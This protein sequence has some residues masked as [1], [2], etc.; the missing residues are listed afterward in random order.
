MQPSKRDRQQEAYIELDGA[1]C[2]YLLSLI[3]EMDSET[4]Y[5]AR[6]RQYTVPKLKLIQVNPSSKRLAHQ[7]VEYL[8]DLI[9]DDDLEECEQQRLMT[10]EKLVKIDELQSHAADQRRSIE[11]QRALRRARRQPAR[12]L[13]KHFEQSK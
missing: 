12:E 11:D 7:D 3:E 2:T 6:Q 9:E 1:D 10:Q 4:A 8:L 5:T 13:Q